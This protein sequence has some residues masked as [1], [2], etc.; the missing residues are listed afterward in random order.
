[1]TKLE[2]LSPQRVLERGYSIVTLD[3]KVVTD[4]N[5][6][7]PGAELKVRLSKGEMTVER[8]N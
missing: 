2:L 6:V 8:K 7:S 4:E 1:M 5:E 3:N